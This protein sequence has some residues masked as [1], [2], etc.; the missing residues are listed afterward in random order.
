MTRWVHFPTKLHIRTKY[1]FV[2]GFVFI[3]YLFY[4]TLTPRRRAGPSYTITTNI[5]EGRKYTLNVREKIPNNYNLTVVLLHGERLDST[6]WE[7]IKTQ[8]IL[9]KKGYRSVA[10]DLP[11]HGFLRRYKPPKEEFEKAFILE[12]LLKELKATEAVLVAPSMSGSYALPIIVRGSLQLKGF[13]PIS[14]YSVENYL[15]AEYSSL[16]IPTM[17]IYGL[18]DKI[19][20]ETSARTLQ[21]IP[22]SKIHVIKDGSHACYLQNPNEFHEVLTNFLSEVELG[23][24]DLTRKEKTLTL[25]SY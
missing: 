14:P 20:G 19:Y 6:V 1:S 23:T 24:F 9:Y 7:E 16:K 10:I 5:I 18:A 25:N 11:G 17:I 22:D 8:E 12:T 2:V 4:I 15:I 21:H 13:V 3:F